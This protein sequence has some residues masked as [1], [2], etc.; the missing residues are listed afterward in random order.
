LKTILS[1]LTHEYHFVYGQILH[2]ALTHVMQAAFM[3]A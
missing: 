3:R 2:E 1:A